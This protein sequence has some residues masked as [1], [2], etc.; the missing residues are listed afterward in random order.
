MQL[1][2][3][4]LSTLLLGQVTEGICV[5]FTV[6]VKLQV[7]VLLLASVTLKVLVVIPTGNADPLAKPAVL[8]VIA[9]VQLSVPVGAV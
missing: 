5:S 7:F 2:K 8:T 9:P 6:T 4:L 3:E 1:P